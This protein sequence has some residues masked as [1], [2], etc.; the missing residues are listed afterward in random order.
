MNAAEALKV[1]RAAGVEVTAEGD[2][3][4]WTACDDPPKRVLAA[5]AEHKAKLLALLRHAPDDPGDDGLEWHGKVEEPIAGDQLEDFGDETEH[6]ARPTIHYWR[7]GDNL[8]GP[9]RSA[10]VPAGM[11][12]LDAADWLDA[13]GLGRVVIIEELPRPTTKAGPRGADGRDAP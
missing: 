7:E 9:G 2:D 4:V 13:R 3:L 12:L 10:P 8:R 5:L 11:A 1:A 6:D